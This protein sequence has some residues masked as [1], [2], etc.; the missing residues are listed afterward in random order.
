M[1]FL[2]FCGIQFVK[3]V[4]ILIAIVLFAIGATYVPDWAWAT[5]LLLAFAYVFLR[6]WWEDYEKQEFKKRK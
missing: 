2:K 5:L 1:G 3:N 6:C 4:I